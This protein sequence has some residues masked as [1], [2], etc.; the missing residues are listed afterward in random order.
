[1]LVNSDPFCF[2][3][4]G[5]DFSYFFG[6]VLSQ[7]AIHEANFSPDRLK[8]IFLLQGV[9]SEYFCHETFFG[10][11]GCS[12]SDV[13]FS[14]DGILNVFDCEL[15]VRRDEILCTLLVEGEPFDVDVIFDVSIG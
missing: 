14:F 4:K 1:L 5:F 11:G 12:E 8:E 10:V 7:S 3:I 6:L 9:G 13:S 15:S 2:F